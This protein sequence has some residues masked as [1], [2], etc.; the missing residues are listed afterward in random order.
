MPIHDTL[1]S[2][3]LHFSA[4][5]VDLPDHPTLDAI[6]KLKGRQK[7]DRATAPTVTTP[8][9]PPP[10]PRNVP[11]H[12]EKLDLT[13]DLPSAKYTARFGPTR[14]RYYDSI[15]TIEYQLRQIPKEGEFSSKEWNVG[16]FFAPLSL[17]VSVAERR[18]CPAAEAGL[19]K[20]LSWAIDMEAL[21]NGAHVSLDEF[22]YDERGNVRRLWD[23]HG[24]VAEPS[25]GILFVHW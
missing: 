6:S 18:D 16:G 12:H 21:R 17:G 10:S 1:Q 19:T 20:V 2:I 23:H 13:L 24:T 8:N 7:R 3:R 9:T 25:D 15:K 4:Q 11:R 22:G 5:Y 14:S